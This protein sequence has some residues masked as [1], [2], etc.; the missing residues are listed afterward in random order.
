MCRF[1]ARDPSMITVAV[2]VSRRA[3]PHHGGVH[4]PGVPHRLLH[5]T[6]V[7]ACRW[8]R[9]AAEKPAVRVRAEGGRER[10]AWQADGGCSI[11]LWT[12]MSMRSANQNSSTHQGG[13]A[14]FSSFPLSITY[15]HCSCSH[16]P[17][18]AYTLPHHAYSKRPLLYAP[19][20]SDQLA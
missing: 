16:L 14:S 17:P 3:V 9:R 12:Q 18:P 11:T 10:E 15:T 1:S 19:L 2:Q 4:R 20:P 6:L 13:N 8:Q 5:Q 7:P